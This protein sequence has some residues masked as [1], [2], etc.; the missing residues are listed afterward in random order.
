M[1]EHQILDLNPWLK[2]GEV[3]TVIPPESIFLCVYDVHLGIDTIDEAA[4]IRRTADTDE[5]WLAIEPDP[6]IIDR[7]SEDPKTI[8]IGLSQAMSLGCAVV[9]GKSSS[10]G[11]AAATLLDALF[12]AR[13]G[14]AWP[15]R[16]TVGG[17]ID[18]DTFGAVV[19]KLKR[20][21]DG[22]AR[23]ASQED[24]AEIVS[25]ARIL[26]LNPQPNGQ[27]PH[28]WRARCPGTNHSL[29]IQSGSDQFGCGYCRRKGDADELQAFYEERTS[30]GS[31]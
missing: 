25:M 12:R 14:L 27:G 8:G 13:V 30:K 9:A 18:R 6:E 31:R 11:S 24:G 2:N 21:L 22:N 16:L 20:E 1:S 3:A 29:Y 26:G 10:D 28:H 19:A 5:L 17:M 4:F 15:T 23:R 7:L